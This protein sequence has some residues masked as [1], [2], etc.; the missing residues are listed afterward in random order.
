MNGPDSDKYSKIYGEKPSK[1][2]SLPTIICRYESWD[3]AE[4]LNKDTIMLTKKNARNEPA[5]HVISLRWSLQFPKNKFRKVKPVKTNPV[6]QAIEI[7]VYRI[8][9]PIKKIDPMT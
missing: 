3:T 7:W 1:A 5:S 6:K 4:K 8:P 9:L 2:I